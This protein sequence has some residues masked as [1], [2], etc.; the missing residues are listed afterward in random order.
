MPVRRYVLALDEDELASTLNPGVTYTVVDASEA[1]F[2]IDIEYVSSNVSD[3]D[4]GMAAQGYAFAEEDPTDPVLTR[5]EKN[6]R[7]DFWRLVLYDRGEYTNQ[8]INKGLD[9]KI[10]K[11]QSELPN[12]PATEST[13]AAIAIVHNGKKDKLCHY[14]FA[15]AEWVPAKK[16]WE[17]DF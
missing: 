16:N 13:T 15:T 8:E 2:D 1:Y 10:Y 14:N 4:E 9:N 11:S 6:Q 7:R 12:P 5:P 3:L 17:K